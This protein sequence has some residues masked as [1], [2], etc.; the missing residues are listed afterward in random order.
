MIKIKDNRLGPEVN[1]CELKPGDTFIW[2]EYPMIVINF[3]SR[4]D[5]VKAVKEDH[6]PCMALA[7]GQYIDIN[8]VAWV[9]PI[10]V[11]M[12]IEE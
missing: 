3:D 6:I 12:S 2:N 8:R 1:L 10:V 4:T 9:T 5:F 7:S 11:E